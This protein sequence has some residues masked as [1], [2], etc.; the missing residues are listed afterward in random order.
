MKTATFLTLAFLLNAAPVRAQGSKYGH[1]R[2]SLTYGFGLALG[3]MGISCE[4]CGTD[5]ST[6]KSYFAFVGGPTKNQHVTAVQFD[7]TT[8][9]ESGETDTFFHFMLNDQ[10]Y[11]SDSS[12]VFLR[13]GIGIG[14][15]SISGKVNGANIDITSTGLAFDLGIGVD[16][17]YA[18]RQS[19]T[20]F[21]DYLFTSDANG[22]VNGQNADEKFNG[23][24]LRIGFALTWH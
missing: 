22:K 2:D 18:N 10:W 8:H 4:D 5:R 13:G 19:I 3:S 17:R 7:F 6:G 24:V 20:P 14:H 16:I 23:N 11:P 12:D 21:V 9:T 15:N 1:A